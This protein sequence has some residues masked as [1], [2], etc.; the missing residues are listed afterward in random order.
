MKHSINRHFRTA[1][2][3]IL[4]VAAV[5]A[6]AAVSPGAKCVAAEVSTSFETNLEGWIAVDG[7]QWSVTENGLTSD[8]KSGIEDEPLKY[9]AR[10]GQKID[11]TKSFKYE[12]EFIIDGYG[13][14][15][16]IFTGSR[17]NFFAVEIN[18]EGHVYF[19]TV[20]ANGWS[21]YAGY[22]TPLSAD[23]I[24]AFAGKHNVLLEYDAGNKT[25][26]VTVDGEVRSEDVTIPSKAF[27]GSLGVYF[28]GCNSCFFTKAL[29]T[30]LGDAEPVDF[31]SNIETNM[32]FECTYGE[33]DY[34]VK[35]LGGSAGG[36]NPK[37]LVK[38]NIE[39][40]GSKSFK[41]EVAYTCKGYGAGMGFGVVDEK[42]YRAVEVNTERHIYFPLMIDGNWSTFYAN[43]PDLTEE[44]A[45][46][47]G[48]TITFVYDASDWF[49]EVYV[50]GVIRQEIYDLDPEVISGSL[51]LFFEDA[52]VYYTKAVYTELET[53]TKAPAE[54]TEAAA[55]TDAPTPA[56]TSVPATQAPEKTPAQSQADKKSSGSDT[57]KILLIIGASA[58]AAVAVVVTAVLVKRKNK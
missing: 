27:G 38:S 53:A 8:M 58:I 21:T 9:L 13:A 50:D 42:N 28:E 26:K 18:K 36:A 55:P 23:E 46:V 14:G 24:A 35:G 43:A 20:G 2:L 57:G 22:G 39:I 48:H 3:I 41:Y 10:S 49:A 34:T 33:I 19:P 54:P 40:D 44:E 47:D 31:K 37:C 25:A 5:T 56:P 45:A 7:S 1:L 51:G 4:A 6:W 52:T 17:T 16:S 29:Y 30:E 11:G 15:L 12:V 32:E